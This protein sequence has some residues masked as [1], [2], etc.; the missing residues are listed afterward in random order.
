MF[1]KRHVKLYRTSSL[2]TEP[3]VTSFDDEPSQVTYCGTHP[4]QPC[5]LR[6]KSS[7]ST[8]NSF[9]CSSCAT[10]RRICSSIVRWCRRWMV[11]KWRP[12]PLDPGK[13]CGTR[14]RRTPLLLGEGWGGSQFGDKPILTK[15]YYN[16]L[17]RSLLAGR[18]LQIL[19]YRQ[20]EI[21][22]LLR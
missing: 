2:S 18:F 20:V 17:K 9:S 13:F 8:A 7:C 11:D 22:D 15:R 16:K 10:S 19:G 3:E 21:C 1:L 14:R 6:L 12:P 5:N 4:F